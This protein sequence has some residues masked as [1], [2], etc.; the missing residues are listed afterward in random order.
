M[1]NIVNNKFEVSIGLSRKWNARAAGKE[2]AKEIIQKLKQPPSFVLLFS[3]IHYKSHGGFHELLK[4]VWEVLPDKTPLI[5]GTIACFVNNYGCFSRGVTALAVSYPNMDVT[6]GLGKNTKISPKKAARNC[7]GMIKL[8]LKNSGYK[9]KLLINMISMGKLPDLPYFGR[10]HIIKSKAI[11]WIATYIGLKVFPYFGYGFGKEEEV[12]DELSRLI[13]E[14]NIIGGSSVDSNDILDNYQFIDKKVM[15]NCIVALGISIDL[16]IDMKTT[17][18][19]HKTNTKFNITKTSRDGRLIKKINNLP[20][21]KQLLDMLKLNEEQFSEF[22]P[23]YYRVSNYLP[24]I[25]EENPKFTSGMGGFFG[26]NIYLGYKSRGKK[27]C[28]CSI[29]GK[30]ILDIIDDNINRGQTEQYPFVFMS[31]SSILLNT[32]GSKSHEIKKMLDTYLNETPYLMIGPITENFGTTNER[33]I[34]RVYSFNSISFKL[35]KL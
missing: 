9:N 6:I 28:L 21:K 15:T 25:F 16:P 26:N 10:I 3:T 18:N 13:P 22:G 35:S 32:L 24:F 14:Y 34:A 12:I 20:A 2:V 1:T 4:G 7:S 29:T 27:A 5:G 19:L 31:S 8:G 30:D 11:G 33:A 17:L 23:F